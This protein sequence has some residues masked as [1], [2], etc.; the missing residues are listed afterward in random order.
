MTHFCY[1]PENKNKLSALRA[2]EAKLRLT[3]PA[4]D[5]LLELDKLKNN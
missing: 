2:L 3:R 1:L 5:H 4:R